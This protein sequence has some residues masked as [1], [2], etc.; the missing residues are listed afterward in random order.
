MDTAKHTAGRIVTHESSRFAPWNPEEQLSLPALNNVRFSRGF[1]RSEPG[2]WFD[3]I[4][5]RWLPFFHSLGLSFVIKD[6]S[7]GL[8]FPEHLARVSVAELDGEKAVIGF[9]RS[10]LDS[11]V[12]GVASDLDPSSFD[13]VVEY[14]E[15][16][17]LSSL[18]L[19]WSGGGEFPCYYLPENADD[20]VEVVGHYRIA[21]E[22]NRSSGTIFIGAGPRL[23]D[24][25]DLLWREHICG[26][27]YR[28]DLG[29][30]E[31]LGFGN[32]GLIVDHNQV[33]FELTELAVPPSKLIDYMRG[34]LVSFDTPLDVKATLVVNDYPVGL[35]NLI[36]FN[37]RFAGEVVEIADQ[38][39]AMVPGT[40]RVQVRL[41]DVVFDRN[42]MI[43]HLQPGAV[44]V[45][46]TPLSSRASLVI[47]GDDVGD[48]VVGEL[49]QKLALHILPK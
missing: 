3:G 32:S 26:L 38:S 7:P 31:S 11:L 9:D 43:E 45:T 1:L 21:Y 15:R 5:N 47:S 48:T 27:S 34:V 16:R 28:G 44:I 6:V 18:T 37:G 20:E 17:L 29:L 2:L 46:R 4:K 33:V 49:D 25:L 40:T 41:A 42:A 8:D 12:S 24:R 19:C 39:R 22:A 13:L 10:G 23:V 35:V 30:Q 36:Q 14:L